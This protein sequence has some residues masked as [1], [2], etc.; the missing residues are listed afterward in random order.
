MHSHRQISTEMQNRVQVWALAGPEHSQSGPFGICT[1]CSGSVLLE[2][3]TE[4]P[5]R[6]GAGYHRGCL[7]TCSSLNK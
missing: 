7:R 6:Y 1:V 2:D 4:G 5:E 3:E